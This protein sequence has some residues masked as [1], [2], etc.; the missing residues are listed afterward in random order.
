MSVSAKH[1]ATI[2]HVTN[3]AEKNLTT[4]GQANQNQRWRH[5]IWSNRNFVENKNGRKFTT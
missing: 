1:A 4:S 2:S 5:D 3:G